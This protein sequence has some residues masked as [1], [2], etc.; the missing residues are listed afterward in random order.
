MAQVEYV[1][2]AHGTTFDGKP[3]RLVITRHGSQYFLDDGLMERP[4]ACHPSV[5]ELE[6]TKKE[7][8]LVLHVKIERFEP[9]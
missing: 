7:A 5:T 9:L 2:A 6:H 1:C 3:A 8:F 4:H